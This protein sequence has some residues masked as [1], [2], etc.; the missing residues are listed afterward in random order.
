M[1]D[2]AF[3]L[4]H[5]HPGSEWILDGDDYAGLTWLSDTPKPT[6]QEITDAYPLAVKALADKEKARLKALSDAR[7]FA[8]SLGFTEAMLAVMYPQLEGA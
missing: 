6:E 5:S 2:I 3:T 8:L 1:I 4:A 7:A